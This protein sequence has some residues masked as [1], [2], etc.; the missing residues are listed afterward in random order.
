[1]T[2]ILGCQ[3]LGCFV[4]WIQYDGAFVILLFVQD[5]VL[6]TASRHFWR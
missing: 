1:M 5:K 6:W 2:P 3:T 4:L